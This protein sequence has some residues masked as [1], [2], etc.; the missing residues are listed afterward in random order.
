MN[1]VLGAGTAKSP[2]VP[3]GVTG[4]YPSGFQACQ[5]AVQ[6]AQYASTQGTRVYS[7]AYGSEN[8]GCLFY[9]NG[10]SGTAGAGDGTDVNPLMSLGTLSYPFGSSG[11][12]LPQPRSVDVNQ[13]ERHLPGYLWI[14]DRGEV[15]S[16]QRHIA[17]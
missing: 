16:Q 1:D 14:I 3:A 7:V 13:L 8:G 5:Q 17:E 12:C 15:D 11:R 2:Y 10:T 9:T 4:T 6:A